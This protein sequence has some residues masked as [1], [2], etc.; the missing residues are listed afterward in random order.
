MKAKIFSLVAALALFGMSAVRAQ[1]Y[2]EDPNYGA[3]V[4][5]REQTARLLM[6]LKDAYDNKAWDE[7]SVY[8]VRLINTAPKAS[9]NIYV[10]GREIYWNK[11]QRAKSKEERLLYAD[12]LMWMY[13][14]RIEAFGDHPQRG[15]A[16]ILAAKATDFIKLAPAEREKFF[17]IVKKALASGSHHLDPD[18]TVLYFNSAVE[19]FKL[20]DITTE[21]L[22]DIYG[23]MNTLLGELPVSGEVNE[24]KG[25]IEILF[26]NS[27][28]AN[29][30]TIEK[31]YRP[32]Y[33]A[34][35]N[36][37]E[38]VE[39]I[40][41]LFQRANCDNDFYATILE[42]YYQHNPK[43]EVALQ[44]AAIFEQKHDYARAQRFLRTALEGQS[45]PVVKANLLVRSAGISLSSGDYRGAASAAQQVLS[46]EPG[47]GYAYLFLAD[48][49]AKGSGSACGDFDQQTVYWLVV[50]NLQQ[51]RKYF[52]DDAA[53]VERINRMIGSYA[54][55]FPKTQ[56]TFMR[57]LQP[58]QAYT[59]SCG[60]I[61]GRTVVR[62][63]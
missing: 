49:Y 51:A 21:E 46:L 55:N 16:Y 3:T 4:E 61:S 7:A 43:P 2:R 23:N 45:D 17:E 12:S 18:L 34:D 14:K 24:A 48:A 36:N 10:R 47:N 53:Q 44:L 5:D 11:A 26:A 39:S 57:N 30:E 27:G 40:L 22:L 13:D 9:M 19:A 42:K 28:A 60:W 25:A 1:D 37:P 63:R 56:E 54:S 41:A 62:E 52:A 20:D 8:V 35:P 32:Q 31:I 58:G 59:V 15:E 38:L 6:M 33:E 29:C 50:D